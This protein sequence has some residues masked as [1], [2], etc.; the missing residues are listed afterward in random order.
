[1][2][3]FDA[4]DNNIAIFRRDIVHFICNIHE[5]IDRVFIF[6]GHFRQYVF[7]ESDE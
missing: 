4:F 5:Q 3:L 1:M 7:N 6:G 2:S